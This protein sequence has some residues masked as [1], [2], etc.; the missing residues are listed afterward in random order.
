MK[1]GMKEDDEKNRKIE[2]EGLPQTAPRKGQVKWET[3][4]KVVRKSTRV[5]KKPD[6]LGNMVMVTKVHQ[7]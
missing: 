2:D 1:K 4:R 3:E 5:P 6:W 7:E